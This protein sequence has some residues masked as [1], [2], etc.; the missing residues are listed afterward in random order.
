MSDPATT[1]DPLFTPIEVEQ[2]ETDDVIAGSAIGKMLSAL[3]LYT[4]LAMSIVG[5]WT[6]WSIQ[7][8]RGPGAE[9]P[10]ADAGHH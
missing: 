10:A 4:I 6:W 3:F 2:F 9:T 7:Q 5:A 8:T 1:E